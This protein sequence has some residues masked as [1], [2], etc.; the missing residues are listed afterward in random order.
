MPHPPETTR[1]VRIG[2]RGSPLAL[3]Q[4][5]H[6]RDRLRAVRPGLEAAVEVIRTAAEK[7]PERPAEA[8]GVGI[9]T[10][11]I[12]EELLA[13][14]IDL[15][16]HS[17]KDVPSEVHPEIAIACVPERETPLDAFVSAGPGG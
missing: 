9:F 8:I 16:V 3:W 1:P 15:A 6:V 12:D 7:F 10:K 4:A 5:N 2:S 11:E 14:R 13:G 17:M